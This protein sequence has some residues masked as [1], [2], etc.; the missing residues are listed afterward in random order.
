M[1]SCAVSEPVPSESAVSDT[2]LSAPSELALLE[3]PLASKCFLGPVFA[4]IM[5]SIFEIKVTIPLIM[6]AN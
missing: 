3:L 2:L 4:V 5:E 6:N 1:C